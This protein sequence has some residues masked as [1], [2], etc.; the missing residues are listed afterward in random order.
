[1]QGFILI[2]F[3]IPSA[4]PSALYIEYAQKTPVGE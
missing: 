3:Y 2:S 1:M 4:K